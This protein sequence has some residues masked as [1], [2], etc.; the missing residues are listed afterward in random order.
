MTFEM[1]NIEPVT[2]ER[3]SGLVDRCLI[4]R[5]D[6]SQPRGTKG[7]VDKRLKILRKMIKD[8]NSGGRT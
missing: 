4:L 3:L 7:E 8:H 5:E 1:P 2:L 6:S